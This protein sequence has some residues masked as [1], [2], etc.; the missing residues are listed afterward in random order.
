MVE[1]FPRGPPFVWTSPLEANRHDALTER[2]RVEQRFVQGSFGE[3]A[4]RAMAGA[5]NALVP[6]DAGALAGLVC[7]AAS[8]DVPDPPPP[9]AAL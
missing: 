2:Q 3:A 7:L 6:E 1:L 8:G 4:L 9:V 5:G